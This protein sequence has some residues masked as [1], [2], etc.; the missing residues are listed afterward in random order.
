MPLLIAVCRTP[1]PEKGGVRVG[2]RALLVGARGGADS[3]RVWG[4]EGH[5]D[6]ETWSRGRV[7]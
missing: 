5:V 7:V 2:H 6:T 1:R 4:R 3:R